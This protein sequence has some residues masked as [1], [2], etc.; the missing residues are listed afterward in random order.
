MIPDS[1]YISLFYF[2]IAYYNFFYLGILYNFLF[3]FKSL[4]MY[5]KQ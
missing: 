1:I 4:K 2:E 3:F 5:A